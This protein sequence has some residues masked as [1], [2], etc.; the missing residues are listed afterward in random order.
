MKRFLIFKNNQSYFRGR[1]SNIPGNNDKKEVR[2]DAKSLNVKQKKTSNQ[3]N[4]SRQ[5]QK[6]DYENLL[7][8]QKIQ[9]VKPSNSVR[10]AFC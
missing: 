9:N 1:T 5:K 4:N 8:L 7:L 6:T 3:I 10:K 2:N